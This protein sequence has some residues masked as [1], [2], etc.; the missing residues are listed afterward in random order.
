MHVA[1]TRATRHQRR[2]SIRLALLLLVAGGLVGWSI[3]V[4]AAYYVLRA[5]DGSPVQKVEQAL[6]PA[7]PVNLRLFGTESRPPPAEHQP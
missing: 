3:F 7:T 6:G 4:V 1:V 5:Y 2:L